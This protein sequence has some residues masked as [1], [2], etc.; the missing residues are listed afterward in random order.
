MAKRKRNSTERKLDLHIVA[1]G[2]ALGWTDADISRAVNAER[3]RREREIQADLLRREGLSEAEIEQKSEN[4]VLSTQNVSRHQIKYDKADAEKL[5]IEIT[6][7]HARE[8]IGRQLMRLDEIWR[9]AMTAW[10]E[11]KQ[12]AREIVVRQSQKMVRHGDSHKAVPVETKAIRTAP[13]AGD[14]RLLKVA[15]EALQERTDLL[16]LRERELA[17]KVTEHPQ[18]DASQPTTLEDAT[19][20]LEATTG[21]RFARHGKLRLVE[22]KNRH[23]R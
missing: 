18:F 17:E 3:A 6:Q 19:R 10:R 11:S 7:K 20:Y 16:R 22:P 5:L 1:M 14:P 23:K 13:R 12:D 15:L 21:S 9:E 4:S 8:E 2:L